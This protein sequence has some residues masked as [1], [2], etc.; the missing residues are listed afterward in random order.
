[1]W[2]PSL[3]YQH[4][5]QA[6]EEETLVTVL[7]SGGSKRSKLLVTDCVVMENCAKLVLAVTKRELQFHDVPT[8]VHSGQT[9]KIKLFGQFL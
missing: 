8:A 7:F 5:F 3:Q 1:M 6:T 2:S 4:G 9:L